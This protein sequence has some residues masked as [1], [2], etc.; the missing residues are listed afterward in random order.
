M[1][2]PL[3]KK[4]IQPITGKPP[5]E[6]QTAYTRFDYNSPFAMVFLRL[7]ESVPLLLLTTSICTLLAYYLLHISLLHLS[8]EKILFTLALVL[9]RICLACGSM[10]TRIIHLLS[11]PDLDCSNLFATTITFSS[12]S[13]CSGCASAVVTPQRRSL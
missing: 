5:N 11:N 6:D 2:L 13:R 7:Q 1:A 9:L 8:L 12:V 4:K 3:V 10:F